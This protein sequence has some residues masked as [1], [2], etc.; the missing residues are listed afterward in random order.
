MTE[1]LSFEFKNTEYHQ[2]WDI[3]CYSNVFKQ[4]SD[5]SICN[6]QYNNINYPE[7][8]RKHRSVTVYMQ[9]N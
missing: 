2:T 5:S 6:V 4:T 8:K 3:Q 9:L 1:Y 7:K